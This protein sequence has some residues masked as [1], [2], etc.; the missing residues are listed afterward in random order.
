MRFWVREND[1]TWD[2]IGPILAI[3]G[4]VGLWVFLFSRM[5]GSS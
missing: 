4:I 1:M 5:K 3:V 2:Q